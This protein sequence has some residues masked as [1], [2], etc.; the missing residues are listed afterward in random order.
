[1]EIAA[2]K[3]FASVHKLVI[4]VIASQDTAPVIS[5]LRVQVMINLKKQRICTKF[6]IE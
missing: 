2:S 1:M 4:F 3:Q 5:V 6:G